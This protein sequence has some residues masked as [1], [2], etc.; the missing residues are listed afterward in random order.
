MVASFP[1]VI[2]LVTLNAV[3]FFNFYF[4]YGSRQ[5][6]FRNDKSTKNLRW[7]SIDSLASIFIWQRHNAEKKAFNFVSGC[8]R[9][10][11]SCDY[12]TK[13]RLNFISI[14][15]V[16][17]WCSHFFVCF[18]AKR[19]R[20]TRSFPSFIKWEKRTKFCCQSKSISWKWT[21]NERTND[22]KGGEERERRE[23]VS[24]K[25]NRKIESS[26]CY[27][28]KNSHSMVFVF[29]PFEFVY[30]FVLLL[31]PFPQIENPISF[32]LLSHSVAYIF[33]AFY[34]LSCN[35][36]FFSIFGTT[37]ILWVIFFFPSIS[38]FEKKCRCCCCAIV[39]FIIR[40]EATVS[41]DKRRRINERKKDRI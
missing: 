27:G 38:S 14:D 3:W 17:A 5:H 6:I 26:V 1:F 20:S 22:G 29:V 24:K 36:W 31:L 40:I 21:R 19:I 8:G 15:I 41:H 33:S 23:W 12:C 39:V 34:I 37:V 4:F 13:C 7:I 9:Q 35:V 2:F 10:C 11:W 30:V 18:K 28:A 25:G 32:N 16:T